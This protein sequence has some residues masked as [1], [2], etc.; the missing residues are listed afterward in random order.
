[1]TGLGQRLVQERLEVLFQVVLW[2]SQPVMMEGGA[3]P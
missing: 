3:A 2:G 1:M